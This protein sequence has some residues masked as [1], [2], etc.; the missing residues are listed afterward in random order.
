MDVDGRLREDV[1]SPMLKVSTYKG[2]TLTGPRDVIVRKVY[3]NQV[4]TAYEGAGGALADQG[5]FTQLNFRILG[6]SPTCM[7]NARCRLVVPLAFYAAASTDA[8]GGN[9]RAAGAEAFDDIAIGPRRNGLL[10]AFSSLSTVINN[11]TS[12][13][14]RPDEAL[15]IAEQA[16]TQVRDIGMTGVNNGEESG[17]WGGIGTDQQSANRYRSE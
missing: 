10:K 15:A 17:Y 14:V 5:S 3:S 16:F 6:T 12:F 11:V 7:L 1:I 13:S 4:V 8:A 2:F 9:A